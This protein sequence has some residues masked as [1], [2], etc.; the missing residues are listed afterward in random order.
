MISLRSCIY[1]VHFA[2][3]MHYVRHVPSHLGLT[4]D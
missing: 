3:F 1:S 2:H 4:W